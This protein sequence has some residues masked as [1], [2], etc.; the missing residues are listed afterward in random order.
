MPKGINDTVIVLIPKKKDPES[1]R[2]FRL[3]SLC[4]II[5][6]VVSK[7]LV[8]RLRQLL[9]EIIVPTESAFILGRMITDN[10]LIASECIH[11]IQK[12]TDERKILCI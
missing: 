9:Q 2:D 4:I 8:N 7:C 1:L 12:C 11:A 5:H 6:K 10:A 3:I